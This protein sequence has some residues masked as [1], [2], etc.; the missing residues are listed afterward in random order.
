MLPTAGALVGLY[1]AT[2]I[3]ASAYCFDA[4]FPLGGWFM[5]A[6]AAGTLFLCYEAGKVI[7]R[8]TTKAE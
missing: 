6:A 5:L 2:L 1:L 3:W 4:G 7:K 8:E